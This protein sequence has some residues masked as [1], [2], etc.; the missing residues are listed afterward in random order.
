MTK[1]GMHIQY[2]SP[3]LQMSSDFQ[4]NSYYTFTLYTSAKE[5]YLSREAWSTSSALSRHLAH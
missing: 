1:L 2:P 4:T 3:A 5:Y